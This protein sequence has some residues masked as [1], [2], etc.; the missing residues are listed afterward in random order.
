MNVGKVVSAQLSTEVG[1]KNDLLNGIDRKKNKLHIDV[2]FKNS[3]RLLLSQIFNRIFFVILQ[4][5]HQQIIS[6]HR[7]NSKFS[8]DS[9]F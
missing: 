1:N 4:T 5:P 9:L 3:L 6:C 2:R 8:S 7:F